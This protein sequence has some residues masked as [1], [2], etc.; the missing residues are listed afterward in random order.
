[1]NTE[2]TIQIAAL[3]SKAVIEAAFH[4]ALCDLE[5]DTG[6]LG[7]KYTIFVLLSFV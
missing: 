1:M 7:M 3:V 6:V 4:G 5:Q 2:R